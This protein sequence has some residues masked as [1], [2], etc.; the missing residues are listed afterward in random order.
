[1]EFSKRANQVSP[2]A[3]LAVSTEAKK[4]AGGRHRRC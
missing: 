2:S 3:T 4:N 1:M